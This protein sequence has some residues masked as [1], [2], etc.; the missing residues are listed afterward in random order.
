M[1]KDGGER[2]LREKEDGQVAAEAGGIPKYLIC[3]ERQEG[4]LRS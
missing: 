2:R 1:R 4:C 3:A